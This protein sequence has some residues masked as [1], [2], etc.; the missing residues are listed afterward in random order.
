M[1]ERALQSIWGG[2]SF[3]FL[4]ARLPDPFIPLNIKDYIQC[5]HQEPDFRKCWA[6]IVFSGRHGCSAVLKISLLMISI[7][8]KYLTAKSLPSLPFHSQANKTSAC[9]TP[10]SLQKNHFSSSVPFTWHLAGPALHLELIWWELSHQ[11]WLSAVWVAI[12]GQVAL[13]SAH[14]QW[15]VSQQSQWSLGCDFPSQNRHPDLAKWLTLSSINCIFH[16][17]MSSVGDKR[18]RWDTCIRCSKWN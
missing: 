18:L 10:C 9:P 4:R 5:T 2:S 16:T 17:S 1:M 12:S 14:I 6:P 7:L 13:D 8:Q 11:L 3:T 15:R